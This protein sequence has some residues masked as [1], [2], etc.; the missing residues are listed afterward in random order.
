MVLKGSGTDMKPHEAAA[1]AALQSAA[2]NRAP[3]EQQAVAHNPAGVPDTKEE[4]HISEN[5]ED[6]TPHTPVVPGA[7]GL[8]VDFNDCQGGDQPECAPVEREPT[9]GLLFVCLVDLDVSGFWGG[10]CVL[11]CVHSLAAFAKRIARCPPQTLSQPR[12][13]LVSLPFEHCDYVTI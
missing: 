7:G 2:A 12:Q 1:R 11:F 4:G 5:W 9:A 8:E 13:I 6:T 10:S 3:Y